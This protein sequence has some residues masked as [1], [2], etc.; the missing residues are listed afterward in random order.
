MKH[1]RNKDPRQDGGQSEGLE[2]LVPD[3]NVHQSE[4]SIEQHLELIGHIS[5]SL[6]VPFCLPKASLYVLGIAVASADV[7]LVEWN[8]EWDCADLSSRFPVGLLSGVEVLSDG[9]SASVPKSDP[10]D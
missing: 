6:S 2:N 1:Q 3:G 9:I 10:F 7:D 8:I 4:F 5:T